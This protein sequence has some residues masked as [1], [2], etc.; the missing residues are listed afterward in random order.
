MSDSETI[1]AE[2]ESEFVE[3][4]KILKFEGLA[5]SGGNAKQAIA[6]GRVSVNGEIE[7]RKRKKIKAGDQIDFIDHH[8]DVIARADG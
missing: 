3:L 6:E 1:I 5:D 2:L 8:I 4:F 7:T